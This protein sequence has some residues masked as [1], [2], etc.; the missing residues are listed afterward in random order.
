MLN[1]SHN[2][3]MTSWKKW[4]L[5]NKKKSRKEVPGKKKKKLKVQ[6]LCHQ[7]IVSW[8]TLH[9]LMSR[10]SKM[11]CK[12]QYNLPLLSW[13]TSQNIFAHNIW[14]PYCI[15]YVVCT[16]IDKAKLDFF[17]LFDRFNISTSFMKHPNQLSNY[18][19]KLH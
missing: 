15:L 12:M 13:S 16:S 7:Q 4:N 8:D 19:S 10:K 6:V 3:Q 11:W 18:H 1:Y 9:F 2:E 17:C 14:A 5:R